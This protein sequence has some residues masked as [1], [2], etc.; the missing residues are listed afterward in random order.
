MLLI[1]GGRDEEVLRLNQEAARRLHAP[2]D[3][4]IVPGATHLFE[5][6]GALDRVADAARQWCDE[7]LRAP[8]G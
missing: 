2:H 1:V 4:R 3:L 7:R 6:P 8:S 5:E